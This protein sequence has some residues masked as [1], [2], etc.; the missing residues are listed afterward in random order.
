MCEWLLNTFIMNIGC[1]KHFVCWSASHNYRRP[2]LQLFYISSV[3]IE[4][5][6]FLPKSVFLFPVHILEDADSG[7]DSQEESGLDDH[8]E[9]AFVPPPGYIMYTVLPDGSPVPQG[10]ALYAPSPPL[11]NNSHPLT[12]GTVVY[13]PPPVGAPIIYG[14]PPANFAVPLVPMGVQHCSVP[15]HHNLVSGDNS[16]IHI[17]PYISVYI[18]LS[19][20]SA[21]SFYMYG[22][23]AP[24]NAGII[25]G[26]TDGYKL[27]HLFYMDIWVLFSYLT[28]GIIPSTLQFQD[29]ISFNYMYWG[30]H[31]N[32]V[33]SE[34]EVR[35]TALGVR[36]LVWVLG[37]EP[38]SSE[39]I[40]VW[41]FPRRHNKHIY[42]SQIGGYN[43]LKCR[44]HQRPT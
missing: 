24:Q 17:V 37:K 21:C 1:W 38:K 7:G 34:T 2:F 16:F 22:E 41:Q 11:P 6:L 33:P 4:V 14:P 12:P 26:L 20:T 42:S 30:V 28:L 13:G 3:L 19:H 32:V 5:L 40:F 29:F 8:G 35:V 36:S 39:R 10:V 25:S 44:C 23:Y 18:K 15:E 43:R 9:P 31:V 27:L